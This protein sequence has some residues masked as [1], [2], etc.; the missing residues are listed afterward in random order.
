[1]KNMTDI[2]NSTFLQYKCP[3]DAAWYETHYRER[4]QNHSYQ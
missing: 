4:I 1:M 2:N 3:E